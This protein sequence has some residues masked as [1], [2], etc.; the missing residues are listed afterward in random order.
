MTI[1]TSHGKARPTL[2]RPSDL[3]PAGAAPERERSH[4]ERGRFVAGNRAG[5]D[6]G[7]KLAIGKA[8]GLRP[9]DAA[10]A[11]VARDAARVLGVV[12]RDMPSD[13]P[14]VRNLAALLARHSA[15]AAYFNCKADELGLDTPEGAKALDVAL[16]HGARAERLTVTC[17]DVATALAKRAEKDPGALDVA[18]IDA[19]AE[20]ETEAR[21]AR[22][23]EA[24][25]G[26]P[27][28]GR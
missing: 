14:T 27:C 24:A 13:G 19:A 20:A 11:A 5:A 9:N 26:A 12:L 22:E 10:V 15:I 21:R 4:D 18:A 16:K 7:A 3:R 2:P 17:L 1:E 23:R 8:L 25:G 28:D 6:R